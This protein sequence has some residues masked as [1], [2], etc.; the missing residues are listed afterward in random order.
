MS[1]WRECRA[2]ASALSK[3]APVTPLPQPGNDAPRVF[4]LHEDQA[5]I[6]R[7]GFNSAGHDAV[8]LNLRLWR[9][10]NALADKNTAADRKQQQQVILGVMLVCVSLHKWQTI[11]L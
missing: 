4:R 2:S 3:S 11:S 7:Y 1:A 8:E 10:G 5:I 6:N 9:A